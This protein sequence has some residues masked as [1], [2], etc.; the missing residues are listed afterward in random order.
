MTDIGLIVGSGLS[1][2]ELDVVA[3][4]HTHTPY[5]PTSSPLLTVSIAGRRVLC[6]ARH[7]EPP[8]IAP[9]EIN[10]RANV[11]A[12]HRHGVRRCI[13]VNIVG[14]IAPDFR[15]GDLAVPHQLIDYTSARQS[16]Y[17]GADG[18]VMHVEFAEPFDPDLR[19]RIAAAGAACGLPLHA[20]GVYG[21]TQ[22]PR[23]ETVAEIDRLARD[24]CTMVGMTAMP[25]AAL[26]RELGVDYAISALAVNWAAG[27]GA[28]D[29]DIH[30]Q[31][32]RHLS[33]GMKRVAALLARLIADLGEPTL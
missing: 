16:T 27:R 14:A 18:V 33:D 28:A 1:R 31:I 22:G 7:G 13:G 12:L 20:G 15:P 6:L 21:V 25:E 10:Y 3:R 32:E 30:A 5:G 11:W 2:L 4:S 8:A 17:G 24:G 29:G 23:L 26:A 19:R 9:H